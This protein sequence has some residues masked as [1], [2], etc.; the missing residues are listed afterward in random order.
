MK[1]SGLFDRY[2]RLGDNG[3]TI[4][5]GAVCIPVF[6]LIVFGALPRLPEGVLGWVLV[7]PLIFVGI[8][9]GSGTA[10][11]ALWVLSAVALGLI[12][13]VSF[14]ARRWPHSN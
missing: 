8:V 1:G 2:A 6:Y 4:V 5:A 7:G 11:F 9:T 13:C 3:Q 12:N 10:A 14:L